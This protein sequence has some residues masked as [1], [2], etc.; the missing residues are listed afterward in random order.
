MVADGMLETAPIIP[1]IFGL[2]CFPITVCL[3]FF[4]PGVFTS[5]CI[6]L[7]TVL[8]IIL[9]GNGTTEIWN[10]DLDV[11]FERGYLALYNFSDKYGHIGRKFLY[12]FVFLIMLP[13]W[14]WSLFSSRKNKRKNNSKLEQYKDAYRKSLHR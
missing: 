2:V 12:S 6:F 4:K 5:F 3:W 13:L 7:S 8:C 10:T 11:I 1:F 9:I 14:I